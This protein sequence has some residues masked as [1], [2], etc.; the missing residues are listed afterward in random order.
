MNLGSLWLVSLAVLFVGSVHA[1]E[2]IRGRGLNYYDPDNLPKL[3]QG[4]PSCDFSERGIGLHLT[5][6]MLKLEKGATGSIAGDLDFMFHYWPNHPLALDL[7]S[8]LVMLQ[9]KQP[10]KFGVLD[11]KVDCYFLQ[12]I[13][14]FPQQGATFMVYGIHLHREGRYQEAIDKYLQAESLGID[15]AEFHYNLGLAYLKAEAFEKAN[16]QARL[17]YAKDYPLPWL[18]DQLI[19][20]GH[21]KN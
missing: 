6:S 11:Q 19:K 14:L 1:C 9:K 7:A 17:A 8:R 2:E 18:Q 12:A 10:R 16:L 5:K 4:R 13:Q 20:A 3:C 15:S 21:W